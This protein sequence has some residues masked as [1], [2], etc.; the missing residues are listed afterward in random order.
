M[1]FYNVYYK[2]KTNKTV[3][4]QKRNRISYLLIIKFSLKKKEKESIDFIGNY[5]FLIFMLK[6]VKLSMPSPN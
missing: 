6:N 2:S 1:L 4:S 3:H 5:V